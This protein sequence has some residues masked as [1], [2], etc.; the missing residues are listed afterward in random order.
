MFN[1]QEG[2]WP[3]KYLGMPVSVD[4][5]KVADWTL[6]EE[7]MEK[8]LAGWKGG[9]L[10]IGGR[11]TLLNAC[12]TATSVYHMS[13]N[14]LP[15]SNLIKLDKIRRRFLWRGDLGRGSTI[16]SPGKSYADQNSKVGREL[17]ILNSLISVLCAN[18]GG[19][20]KLNQGRGRN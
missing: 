2:A 20:W 10:S 3:I 13:M 4:K 12:L 15:K 6:L 1:C 5:L 19:N 17:R 14:L 11:V 18:G 7:K 16:L 8:K 9:A